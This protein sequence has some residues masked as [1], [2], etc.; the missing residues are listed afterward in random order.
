MPAGTSGRQIS[1]NE[2]SGH[3]WQQIVILAK[4]NFAKA[5]ACTA[6]QGQQWH[7]CQSS[8][9]MQGTTELSAPHLTSELQGTAE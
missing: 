7:G 5:A 6:R 2:Q 3:T 1:R 9:Q 4:A 8:A